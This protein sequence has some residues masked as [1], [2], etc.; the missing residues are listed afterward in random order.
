MIGL[1]FASVLV[2]CNLLTWTESVPVSPLITS[3]GNRRLNDS[4][5]MFLAVLDGV[6]TVM[7][8]PGVYNRPQ[9]QTIVSALTQFDPQLYHSQENGWR[10]LVAYYQ[11]GGGVADPWGSTPSNLTERNST[12]LK[13]PYHQTLLVFE[14]CNFASNIAYYHM[15]IA[16]A[17]Y[18]KWA[19]SPAVVRGLAQASAGLALGSAFW[20]GSNTEL[21]GEADTV[22]I[23][24]MAYIMQQASMEHL[25][26]NVKTPILSDLKLESRSMSGVGIAQVLTDMY[27]TEPNSNWLKILTTLDIPSYETSFAAL[28]TSLLTLLFPEPVVHPAA[29]TLIDLFGIDPPTKNFILQAYIP[30]VRRALTPIEI[31]PVERIDLLFSTV[32]TV[33]KLVYA[34]LFQEITFNIEF[35]KSPLAT[36]LGAVF[37]PLLNAKSGFPSTLPH[38][39][40][41][42]S[43]GQ[44]LYPGDAWCRSSQPHS[45]WHAQSAAGLIDFFLLVDKVVKILYD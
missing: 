30:E 13:L 31:T 26:P 9:F 44:G 21:G 29:S 38:L 12:L 25:P 28:I 10:G 6:Q 4:W 36:Q 22:M 20:H 8:G 33:K 17:S 40:P 34:F 14:P 18:H 43:S 5:S 32:R 23:A 24:V 7:T 11:E 16:L 15:N 42:L 3:D 45:L 1:F 41:R 2:Y 39:S 27:R 37:Q 19:L 35:L